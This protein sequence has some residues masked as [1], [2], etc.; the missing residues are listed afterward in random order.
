MDLMPIKVKKLHKDAIIP[1]YQS[2]EAACFDVHAIINENNPCFTKKLIWDDYD[3]VIKPEGPGLVVQPMSQCIVPTGLAFGLPPF[4][5]LQIRPRSGLAAKK[6]IT[7]TNSPGTLDSDYLDELK[8]II[9]NLG[10]KPFI[11]NQGDRIA[12]CK[13]CPIYQAEFEEVLDFDEEIKKRDRG[14]GFG[15]TGINNI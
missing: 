12:Q 14:G 2:K 10:K 9:F 1:K 5:E 15:S 3:G 6:C 4:Y 8:I 7:I 11:I 13:V